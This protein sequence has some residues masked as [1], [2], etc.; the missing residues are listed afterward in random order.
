[1]YSSPFRSGSVSNVT[2]RQNMGPTGGEMSANRSLDLFSG[3]V[4]ALGGE[5]L[6]LQPIREQ[7][8]G[9]CQGCGA[10]RCLGHVHGA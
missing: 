2:R 1:M 9:V 7:P 6:G 4:E 10:L 8:R 3:A 5:L